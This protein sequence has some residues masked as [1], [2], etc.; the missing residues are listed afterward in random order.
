[1]VP[2]P[3]V[4]P[5]RTVPTVRSAHQPAPGGGDRGRMSDPTL[6]SW[7]TLLAGLL[8]SL[9]A[10]VVRGF[11]GF[12][13]SALTVAGLSLFVAPATIVPAVLTLEV[14]AS[15]SMW[16]SAW[17]DADRGWL[18]WLLAGNLVFIPVG[19][20]LL[21]WLPPIDLRLVVGLALLV[22]AVLMRLAGTRR[23][24]PT[25]RLKAGA[26]LAS[27]LLNGVAASGGVAAAMLL[28]AAGVQ[29]AALRATMVSMLFVAGLYALLCAALIP[30][31]QGTGLLS[32]DTLR[33][34]LLLAPTMLAGIGIGRRAFAHIDA[35]GFR[36]HVL[37]L[38]I[39]IAALGTLRA[40]VD[41]WAVGHT[42]PAAPTSTASLT[43]AT[44][45]TGVADPVKGAAS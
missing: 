25:T 4:G 27:G 6:W 43:G 17:R 23:F 3:P 8:V 13:Y 12:G 15:V 37:T 22:A 14:V 29:A 39:V 33:W 35:G 31:A 19:I 38:L 36:H 20:G 18:G 44:S 10:G 42:S 45:P 34:G 16:R 9:G 41:R 24:A 40:A 2:A 21:A 30:Q 7:P 28:T 26:G 1:M 5:V 32:M 11:A